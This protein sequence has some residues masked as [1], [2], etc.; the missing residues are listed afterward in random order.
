ME[1]A[2]EAGADDVAAA[3]GAWEVTCSPAELHK[4]RDAIVAGGVEP[5]SA[6]ITMLPKT[7]VACD[8]ESAAK[9]MRLIDELE[10]HDDAQKVY[11]NAEIPEEVMEKLG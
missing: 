11:H 4:V 9:V 6:E 1:L 10:D 7:T 3:D 8:A 2:L 5:D